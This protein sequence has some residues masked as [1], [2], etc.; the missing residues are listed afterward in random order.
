M[1]GEVS[2][3]DCATSCHAVESDVV[4]PVAASQPACTCCS[5]HPGDHKGE[6]GNAEGGFYSVPAYT[7]APTTLVPCT[8]AASAVVKA[9]SMVHACVTWLAVFRAAPPMPS[10]TEAATAARHA[11]RFKSRGDTA[12]HAACSVGDERM[13]II[14]CLCEAPYGAAINIRADADG[15]TPLMRCCESGAIECAKYI[16]SRGADVNMVDNSG[17]GVLHWALQVGVCSCVPRVGVVSI[18]LVAHALVTTFGC[19][20]RHVL[21]RSS[22]RCASCITMRRL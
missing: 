11:A 15:A 7:P 4:A 17:C 10:S 21:G 19:L 8:R 2:Q 3:D 20:S 22:R 1:S 18:A 12:L 6:G 14:K 5:H 9:L 13:E 16:V